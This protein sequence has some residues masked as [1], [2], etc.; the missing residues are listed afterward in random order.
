MIAKSVIGVLAAVLLVLL[1]Q[2]MKHEQAQIDPGAPL[3]AKKILAVLHAHNR[4]CDTVISY[5]PVG[6]D[7]DGKLDG[8]LARCGDGGRYIYFQNP[9]LGIVGAASCQEEAFRYAYRCPD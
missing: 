9:G 6:K 3:D 1:Y 2:R 4:S 7:R 5:T 8:Y